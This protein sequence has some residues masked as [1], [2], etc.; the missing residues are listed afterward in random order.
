V[1]GG[2]NEERQRA[3]VIADVERESTAVEGELAGE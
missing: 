3:V 2:E 1:L